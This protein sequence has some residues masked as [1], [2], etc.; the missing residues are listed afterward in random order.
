MATIGLNLASSTIGNISRHAFDAWMAAVTVLAVA[1]IAVY[2]PGSIRRLSILV[3]G[4]ITYIITLVLGLLG[5]GTRLDFSSV[6]KAA[7]IGLPHFQTP[8]FSGKAISLIAPVVIILIA[9]N[10]GHVRAVSAMTH[11]NLDKYLGRAFM[12]DAVATTIAGFGGSVGVTTYAENIGVMAVTRIYSTLIFIVASVVAILLGFCPK[13]GAIIS[14]IPEGVF[15][16]LSIVL[17]GLIA[18][19]GAR[20][21]VENRVDFSKSRNLITAGVSLILGSGMVG[22]LAVKF[23]NVTFDG[24]GVAT[25]TAIVLYQILREGE[26]VP[27]E[28][29]VADAAV[30]PTAPSDPSDPSHSSLNES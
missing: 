2:A 1:F 9:E 17:F 21:W 7:W 23:G 4:V 25:F 16:G 22:G 27:E 20:I 29:A 19:S 13:F 15:G 26:S 24:I 3:G 28:S 14:T 11:R 12:G 10:I 8:Q 6:A 5:V 30:S 18:I